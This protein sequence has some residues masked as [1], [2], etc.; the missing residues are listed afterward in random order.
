MAMKAYSVS[1]KNGDTGYSYIIFAETRGK[2]IRYAMDHSEGTFDWYTWTEMR[3]IREPILDQYYHGKQ[4]LDWSD[5]ADRIIMVRDAGFYCSY[6]YD[7]DPGE[8]EEC[9]AHEWCSRYKSMTED[10]EYGA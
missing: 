4:Q 6:E 9:P 5:D 1:D 10:K 3:A 8:C 7:P 2:A